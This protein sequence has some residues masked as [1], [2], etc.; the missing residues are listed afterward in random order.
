MQKRERAPHHSLDAVSHQRLSPTQETCN[1]R[2]ARP[3]LNYQWPNLSDF[4][5]FLSKVAD[6]EEP[7][8]ELLTK[9][10]AL[11]PSAQE[12]ALLCVGQDE[13]HTI[14]ATTEG[15]L[16]DVVLPPI[17]PLINSLPRQ[18]LLYRSGALL[19]LHGNLQSDPYDA[20]IQG[21]LGERWA[22][23]ALLYI[24][25][26][27]QGTLLG[28]LLLRHPD[29]PDAFTLGDTQLLEFL[30]GQTGL[31]LEN[32]Y[33]HRAVTEG[34]RK[35]KTLFD[36]VDVDGIE[37]QLY[38]HDLEYN[39]IIANTSKL[40]S[41]HLTAEQIAGQKC[42]QAFH[43]RA[44]PCP[45]CPAHETFKTKKSAAVELSLSE[46]EKVLKT[47]TYPLTG[48]A[49]NLLGVVH[50]MHDVTEQKSLE[51]ENER[52]GRLAALG[53]LSA[54][55][56]HEIRNPLSGVGISAQAL[57][58]SLHP[59]DF[60]ESNLKNILKG[61]RK[62]DD[63]IKGLLDFAT[64]KEPVLTPVS[65]N[66]VLEEALFFSAPQAQESR[67][68]IEKDLGKTLPLVLL[69]AEQIKRVFINIIL[70]ALQAMSPG[71]VLR[72]RTTKSAGGRVMVRITDTG[73]G[74]SP[75][76]LK[77]IFDPFFTTKSQGAG[78]G[79]SISRTILEKHH[80]TIACDS[81]E[82]IGTTFTLLFQGQRQ[83]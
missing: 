71:G 25:F 46:G 68:S 52:M 63:V 37:E 75:V 24:P 48:K 72:I 3:E 82:G 77:R 34:R 16:A 49:G 74:I 35:F 41:Y 59:G 43:H 17:G 10:L 65:V 44:T 58:R 13:G 42:Y 62:V 11:V 39:L 32:M 6:T 14:V 26:L 7:P 31:A 19:D 2:I 54:V 40:R 8:T 50:Y 81:Q 61:I 36:V 27:R 67:I 69:D 18:N 78:L 66:K 55:I 47:Y 80:A 56:A 57:S 12:G 5:T 76:I 1:G 60:H 73:A 53:E 21:L 45:G 51:R 64:P 29:D 4:G 33:L 70:N 22:H 9:I 83:R 30:A 38:V 15:F 28:A 79:L 23:G 20:M